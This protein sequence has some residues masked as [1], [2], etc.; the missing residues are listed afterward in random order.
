MAFIWRFFFNFILISI[1]N[2]FRCAFA[3]NLV[4]GREFVLKATWLLT[5][6]TVGF[7]FLRDFYPLISMRN[8]LLN[9]DHS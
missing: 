1:A 6:Q 9:T 3:V 7:G 5:L 4:T 8:R 2:E